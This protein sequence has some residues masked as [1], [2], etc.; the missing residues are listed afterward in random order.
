MPHGSYALSVATVGIDNKTS[1][2]K[3]LA[4]EIAPPWYLSKWS[5]ALY[6][7]AL[8]CTI[9]IIRWYNRRKYTRKQ[10]ALQKRLHREHAE[11]IMALE[12]EKLEKE[13][14]QKQKE[15]ARTTLSVAK[16]NELILEL[17]DMLA[18]NKDAFFNK[19]RYRSLT[20]KLDTSINEDEDW[21]HFE[22]NFKE[23]HGDFF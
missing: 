18:L 17:K 19:Q 1:A 13:I 7:L 21:K 11:Q 4:F 10:V 2:P 16:K 20:K 22:I 6:V 12:K 8:F 23:L 3:K 15:L 5:V 14:R 9:F